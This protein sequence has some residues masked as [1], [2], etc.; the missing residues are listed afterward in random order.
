MST[1]NALIFHKMN[2][3][4]EYFK[5]FSHKITF[6]NLLNKIFLHLQQYKV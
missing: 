6:L 1:L 2:E 4:F 5:K 3:L